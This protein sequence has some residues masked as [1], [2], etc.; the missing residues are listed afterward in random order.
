MKGEYH[1]S[2]M[3]WERFKG[4]MALFQ[5]PLSET[6]NEVLCEDHQIF[7]ISTNFFMK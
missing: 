2:L 7:D 4:T 6:L 3:P 5:G 1:F